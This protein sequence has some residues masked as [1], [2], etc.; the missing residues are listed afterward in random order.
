[1]TCEET[2]GL[3]SEFLEQ[4]L[5]ADLVGALERHLQD[6]APCV[7]YLNTYKKTRELTGSSQRAPMPE[8]MKQRLRELLR[9]ALTKKNG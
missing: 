7:A 8:E 3:L 2:I 9:E 4:E 5:D 1:M 6:C